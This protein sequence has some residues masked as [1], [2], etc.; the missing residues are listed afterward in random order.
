VSFFVKGC[1][2]VHRFKVDVSKTVLVPPFYCA[3]V[4]WDPPWWNFLHLDYMLH[5]LTKA[6]IICHRQVL[7]HAVPPHFQQWL[8][9][10]KLLIQDDG[11]YLHDHPKYH[12][13]PG[14]RLPPIVQQFGTVVYHWHIL[15]ADHASRP[16]IT[17]CLVCFD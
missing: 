7:Q 3:K 14:G 12:L 6:E 17:T 8:Y 11:L 16:Y 9:E 4:R 10:L 15:P 2:T 5:N 1:A 13:D